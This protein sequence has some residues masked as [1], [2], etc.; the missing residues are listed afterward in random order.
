MKK[1]VVNDVIILQGK[2]DTIFVTRHSMLTNKIH[3]ISF[4]GVRFE[5]MADWMESRMKRIPGTPMVQEAFPHLSKED[6]EFLMTGITAEEWLA[7]FP[8]EKEE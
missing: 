1:A 7:V 6:R 4:G 3:T 8:P 5:E 2:Y